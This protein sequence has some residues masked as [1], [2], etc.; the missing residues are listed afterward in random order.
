MQ[1]MNLEGP[2]VLTLPEKID[3]EGEAGEGKRKKKPDKNPEPPLG[4]RKT[5]SEDV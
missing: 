5:R 1:Y 2:P 4:G 3:R